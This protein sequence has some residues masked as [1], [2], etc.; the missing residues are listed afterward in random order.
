MPFTDP[1]LTPMKMNA[2]NRLTMP[3]KQ[4]G[5]FQRIDKGEFQCIGQTLWSVYIDKFCNTSAIIDIHS[6]ILK[7]WHW[8]RPRRQTTQ[9]YIRNYLI[10]EEELYEVDNEVDDVLLY[11]LLRKCCSSE[12][13]VWPRLQLYQV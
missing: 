10:I 8:P 9:R 1:T 2:N 12:L 13:C 6:H 3:E 5:S 11:C 4:Q 7:H